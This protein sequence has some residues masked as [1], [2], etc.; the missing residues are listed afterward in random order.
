M[1]SHSTLELSDGSVVDDPLGGKVLTGVFGF[2]TAQDLEGVIT[3]MLTIHPG[4]ADFVVVPR[5][6]G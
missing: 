4:L 6:C 1:T 3:Q 2:D 5:V